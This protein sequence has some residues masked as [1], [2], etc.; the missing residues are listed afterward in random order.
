MLV[1]L[2]ALRVYCAFTLAP[3]SD[4]P[5]HLHVVWAWTQ[6][7]V[8]Y[9]D[10]FDNHA[11]LFQLLCAPLLGWLGERADIVA[12]MRLAM[13]PLYLCALWTTWRIGTSLWSRRVG[14]LAAVLVAT[15]PIFFRV[16]AQFRPDD[17]WMVLWLGVVAVGV[18][19]GSARRRAL[20]G[21]VLLGAAFAVSLKSTLLV[22]TA[23]AAWLIVLPIAKPSA[24]RPSRAWIAPIACGLLAALSIPAMLAAYFVAVGAGRDAVY[25]LFTH[26]LVADLGHWSGDDWRLLIPALGG[27][28]SVGW[29]WL[30]RPAEGDS[31]RWRPRAIAMLSAVFYLLVLYGCWPL[32][33]HQDLLPA[34]PL[35]GVGIAAVIL[36]ERG[37]AQ[38]RLRILLAVAVAAAGAADLAFA[39]IPQHDELRDH[40][41]ELA[42]VLKLT[43]ADD[44][45]M[46]AKGEAIFRTR[47]IYWV[48]EGITEARMRSGSI[49][50]DIA[51]RLASMATPVV[52]ADRLPPDDARFVAANYLPVGGMLRIAGQSFGHVRRGQ[53]VSFDIRVPGEYELIA[54]GAEAHG[55]LDGLPSMGPKRLETGR[56]QVVASRDSELAL[57]WAPAL[58]RGL[59]PTDVFTR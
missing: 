29:L 46:D 30:T 56:H 53:A 27:P 17:L 12:L 19:R 39:G 59:K 13:I 2:V 3:N 4:E 9:R 42:R 37:A 36:P 55:E 33:T 10:V 47:P 58:R 40:E 8:P 48:L 45:V 34:I 1:P 44:P 57:V 41:A 52:I 25:C 15:A 31:G 26:N 35:I 38:K 5:Q 22:A 24:L 6:G 49:R 14:A 20:L 16:S 32:V 11:P 54:A 50:D 21:G 43:H 28:L 18:S 7:L 23:A 51:E